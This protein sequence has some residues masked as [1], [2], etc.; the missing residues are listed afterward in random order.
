MFPWHVCRPMSL[1]L[2]LFDKRRALNS[3]VSQ[4]LG[5]NA[6]GLGFP[7]PM[8]PKCE[9]VMSSSVLISVASCHVSVA[10]FNGCFI[11]YFI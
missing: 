10:C 1:V 7:E 5:W 6:Q 4:L 11:S 2:V 3:T 8:T 9:T